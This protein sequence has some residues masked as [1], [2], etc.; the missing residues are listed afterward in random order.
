MGASTAQPTPYS[1]AALPSAADS[2]P[3]SPSSQKRIGKLADVVLANL[4]KL[5][6]TSGV[7][8]SHSRNSIEKQLSK[9]FPT[10]QT[11]DHPTYAVM[12]RRAIQE[13]N[14]E[15][16]SSEESISKFIKAEYQDLPWGHTSLLSHHLKKLSECGDIVSA[17]ANR[18]V[19]TVGDNNISVP[20]RRDKGKRGGRL[21]SERKKLRKKKD[22]LSEKENVGAEDISKQQGLVIQV[23]NP[24]KKALP[25]VRGT[26]GK[27]Q[28]QHQ[29]VQL[30]RQKELDVMNEG[31]IGVEANEVL[32]E[33][34]MQECERIEILEKAQGGTFQAI[35]E[36]KRE[37]QQSVAVQL[38][39]ER[40]QQHEIIEESR[41]AEQENEVIENQ[42][43]LC[44]QHDKDHSQSIVHKDEHGKDHCQSIVHEDEA[45]K[46]IDVVVVEQNPQH[47][48]QDNEAMEEDYA[49]DDLDGKL[50]EQDKDQQYEI[51]GLQLQMLEEEIAGMGELTN[52][53]RQQIELADENVVA[54]ETLIESRN[55]STAVGM[56]QEQLREKQGEI[57]SV[58]VGPDPLPSAHT[59]EEVGPSHISKEKCIQLLKRNKEIE[60]RLM[61]IL[62]SW[63]A[64]EASTHVPWQ[65]LLVEGKDHKAAQ[66]QPLTSDG[67]EIEISTQMCQQE[68]THTQLKAPI[69]N[70]K[71]QAEFS[72][73]KRSPEVEAAVLHNQSMRETQPK[74]SDHD[75]T[76][77]LEVEPEAQTT[78]LLVDKSAGSGSITTG[79]S[80]DVPLVDLGKVKKVQETEISAPKY[81]AES[82]SQQ[83]PP[84]SQSDAAIFAREDVQAYEQ[85]QLL[86]HSHKGKTSLVRLP[87]KEATALPHVPVDLEHGERNQTSYQLDG[88]RQQELSVQGHA[89]VLEAA[90]FMPPCQTQPQNLGQQQQAKLQPW[91]QGFLNVKGNGASAFRMESISPHS[92]QLSPERH[93]F[94]ESQ[95]SS[96]S[97]F[98]DGLPTA[99]HHD[100]VQDELLRGKFLPRG[101]KLPHS[102]ASA[103]PLINER[104]NKANKNS[105]PIRCYGLELFDRE[106]VSPFSFLPKSLQPEQKR[107]RL[108]QQKP[109]QSEK[110]A[111]TPKM[112]LLRH[113]QPWELKSIGN[114]SQ[115]DEPNLQIEE[116]ESNHQVSKMKLGILHKSVYIPQQHRTSGRRTKQQMFQQQSL[117]YRNKLRP[118]ASGPTEDD[119]GL[120]VVPADFLPLNHET[121]VNAVVQPQIVQQGQ[122]QLKRHGRPPQTKQQGQ[123]EIKR[124]GRSPKLRLDEDGVVRNP[125][126]DQHHEQ[127]CGP[128][129]GSPRKRKAS[130]ATNEGVL[131][132]SEHAQRRHLGRPPKAKPVLHAGLVNLA[133]IDKP[134]RVELL[135]GATNGQLADGE[136]IEKP[137]PELA[138][139]TLQVPREGELPGVRCMVSWTQSSNLMGEVATGAVV[140]KST[141]QA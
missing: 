53:P 103:P 71:K 107:R 16:G 122:P 60:G 76:R 82:F 118:R 75:L 38:K 97:A 125:H 109:L 111:T 26:E 89:M 106:A 105:R 2:V 124:C 119:P 90:K 40:P 32:H 104:E 70:V 4:A 44:E 42:A 88:E 110:M 27:Y 114:R 94:L 43:Q 5:G 81:R 133:E 66:G 45:Q 36:G 49:G 138:C 10:F 69:F 132:S 55:R 1:T 112:L 127:S 64:M 78:N 115:Q 113:E 87:F 51:L 84:E 6:P 92:K 100:Q 73:S 134:Q 95:T 129:R 47:Q 20:D 102:E 33:A 52:H 21:R 18:Y 65:N 30:N 91:G 22:S 62:E 101:C 31:R 48:T 17:S 128:V 61:A 9:L 50:V 86:E 11:P 8:A 135:S 139:A 79:A 117:L 29:Q 46:Q 37:C 85:A 131:P 121:A 83:K 72:S 80:F 19:L 68:G 77:S 98:A 96:A 56:V 63:N 126:L 13:L 116:P 12:I 136:R 123:P 24:L 54:Q 34:H 74:L 7:P 23:T 15:G 35:E 120:D 93:K 130:D 58:V 57:L 137:L 99:V 67:G 41:P 3:L 14:E 28:L 25:S 39:E 108:L 140:T 141:G 59:F